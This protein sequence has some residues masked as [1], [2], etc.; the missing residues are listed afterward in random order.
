MKDWDAPLHYAVSA[1][2]PAARR[3]TK[4]LL[5]LELLEMSCSGAE[6]PFVSSKGMARLLDIAILTGNKEA[7]LHFHMF[8]AM[9]PPRKMNAK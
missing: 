4:K 3:A 2:V 6:L 7:Q 1:T 9:H 5:V 8:S